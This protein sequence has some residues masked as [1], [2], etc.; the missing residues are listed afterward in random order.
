MNS[1]DGIQTK[2]RKFNEKIEFET[3]LKHTNLIYNLNYVKILID[4]TKMIT[5]DSLIN[6]QIE[7][8]YD[9]KNHLKKISFSLYQSG[10]YILCYYFI[11]SIND[12][13]SFHLTDM[14]ADIIVKNSTGK[15][16]E[17]KYV[18]YKPL[19]I[20]IMYS[21]CALMLFP[22]VIW[23][24]IIAK[25]KK[26]KQ[27]KLQEQDKNRL[28]SS[29]T[30]NSNLIE[31]NSSSEKL[32]TSPNADTEFYFY[33]LVHFDRKISIESQINKN[34]IEPDHILN[35][36]PWLLNDTPITDTK[37]SYTDFSI[38]IPTIIPSSSINDDD[39]K[40]RVTKKQKKKEVKFRDKPRETSTLEY[41]GQV[42]VTRNEIEKIR[43]YFLF[44]SNV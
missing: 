44:E 11:N 1:L 10:Y 7:V 25:T 27:K 33:N 28:V 34:I 22:V 36:K 18:Y 37:L 4:R 9:D 13:L 35:S 39:R 40:I 38:K 29:N 43:N 19:F 17:Q 16:H 31:T 6:N 3:I 41:N 5:N 14:C 8:L 15:M 32:L 23:K 21:L 42:I 30:E 24:N 2:L 26:S 12:N 20:P